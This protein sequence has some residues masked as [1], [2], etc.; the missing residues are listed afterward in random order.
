MIEVSTSL[1]SIKEDLYQNIKKLNNTSTDY[2]H[3]DIMDGKFVN[4]TSFNFDEIKKISTI[5]SKP[6][7][8]HLMVK[9]P[10]SYT[11]EYKTLNPKYITIHYE[12][13]NL[14]KYIK[15]IKDNNIKI[16]ISIKPE[17]DVENIIPLIKEIDLVLVMSVDPGYG[18][19][20]F[21]D[22][23]LDKIYNL[24]KYINGNK[25]N[26][27][28]EVDGGINNINSKK[29]IDNGVD[30][31]VSGSYITNSDNYEEQIKKLRN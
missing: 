31:L 4:N 3:V 2:I 15:Q 27:L 25:L 28:I 9:N 7:D 26:T 6:L 30:I 14:D 20:K 22:T 10:E 16:G 18:G 19:Q 11:E 5:T 23:S 12:I 1:L 17:T 8:V 24:K 21:I 13:D 29:C